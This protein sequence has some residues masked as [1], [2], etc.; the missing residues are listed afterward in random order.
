MAIQFNT[1][2][3]RR[4][5]PIM[6][7][8]KFFGDEEFNLEM[9]FG[10]EYVEEDAN[11]TVVLYEVDLSKTQVDDIYMEA[12][13]D[14]IRTKQPVEIPVVFELGEAELETYDK[15]RSRGFYSKTG[16]LTFGVFEATLKEYGCD[17]KRGDYIGLQVTTEHMEYFT[18]TNDGRIN[19]DNKH[20][21][22]GTKPYYR[23]IECAVVDSVEFEG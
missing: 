5:N 2:N 15:T 10:Q 8:S 23:T 4:R 16:K 9:S 17:I 3:I 21:M 7:N 11:Q 1:N 12:N 20:T 6:R 19:Y 18:V 14:A 22:Y 13:Q